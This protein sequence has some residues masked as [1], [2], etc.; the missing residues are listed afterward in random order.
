VQFR[1]HPASLA[2]GTP[3]YLGGEYLKCGDVDRTHE[4]NSISATAF[5]Y[6]FFALQ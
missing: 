2:L 3:P 1:N 5:R 4:P 6:C